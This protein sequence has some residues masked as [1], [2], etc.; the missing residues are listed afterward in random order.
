MRRR[1]L[2]A[3]PDLLRLRCP[4]FACAAV[5]LSSAL[6]GHG[7]PAASDVRPIDPTL[8]VANLVVRELAPNQPVS[9]LPAAL[10]GSGYRLAPVDRALYRQIFD[11]TAAHDHAT[12]DQL[13]ARVEDSRLRGHVLAQRWLGDPASQPDFATLKQ[14]LDQYSDLPQADQVLALAKAKRPAGAPLPKLGVPGTAAV[15]V[16]RGVPEP[17]NRMAEIAAQAFYDGDARKALPAAT[18]ALATLGNRAT[19]TRWIAGLAAWRLSQFEEASRHFEALSTHRGLTPWMQSAANYWAGRAR[20]QLGDING[21]QRWWARAAQHRTTFYGLLA[22]RSLSPNVDLA[23]KPSSLAGDHVAQLA[24]TPA[25]YRAI[26]LLDVGEF[27]LAQAELEEIDYDRHAELR[28]PALAVGDALRMTQLV[29]DLTEPASMSR[30]VASQYPIPPW[31]PRGGFAVDPAL[32]YALV[33][34]ESKFD[35][36]ARNASGATGLMQLMP[37]T[38][39]SIGGD[40]VRAQLTDPE[41]NLALGQTYVSKLLKDPDIDGDLFLMAV[42]YNVGP[43]ALTRWRKAI[44]ETEDPLIFIEQLPKAETRQF[45][46]RVLTNYWIYRLKF[47]Q[48]VPSLAQLAAG[49][50]P[51]YEWKKPKRLAE[52]VQ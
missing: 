2:N 30:Y 32:V 50:W 23:I 40:Q 28:E 37:G 51:Q 20:K 41:T 47:R 48:D 8:Q 3:G 10:E 45:I 18:A 39:A 13:L 9:Y 42:A 34:Q 46:Q 21:A 31:Q 5:I 44:E 16:E 22:Q 7:K 15:A 19:D 35:P 6:A 27:K 11:L 1:I 49:E 14:W 52:V 4:F 29:R 17:A 26:A 12:A 38:A 43:G 24:E 33:K 36:Q 25:G